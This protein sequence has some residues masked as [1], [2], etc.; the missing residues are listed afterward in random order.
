MSRLWQASGVELVL[1]VA[2]LAVLVVIA[3]Y[4]IGKVRDEAKQARM[5]SSEILSNF[6]QLHESGQLSDQEF[7]SIR[8]MLHERMQTEIAQTAVRQQPAAAS[9]GT[10]LE[11][12]RSAPAAE[13]ETA[14]E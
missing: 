10:A 14:T 2:L 1:L 11:G 8:A 6:E 9:G 5:P 7:R 3:I 4:L 13:G 12:G